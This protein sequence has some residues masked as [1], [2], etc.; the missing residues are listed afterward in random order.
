MDLSI[1]PLTSCT[2]LHMD[3]DGL[4]GGGRCLVTW[5]KVTRPAELGGMGVLDLTTLGYAL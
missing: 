5:S 2:W 1:V 4:R 3:G